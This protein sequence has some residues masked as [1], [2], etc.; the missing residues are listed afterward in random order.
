MEVS[1]S[2][3]AENLVGRTE[4]IPFDFIF[5]SEDTQRKPS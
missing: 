4:Q 3:E 1:R 2:R 5:G